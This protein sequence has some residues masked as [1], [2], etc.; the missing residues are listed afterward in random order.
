MPA[1]V[2]RLQAKWRQVSRVESVGWRGRSVLPW[3]GRRDSVGPCSSTPRA[4]LRWRASRET[5]RAVKRLDLSV[6][7]ALHQHVSCRRRLAPADKIG[8]YALRR[9]SARARLPRLRMCV[10][11][12][13]GSLPTG[14]RGLVNAFVLFAVQQRTTLH[15]LP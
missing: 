3:A 9:H 12:D 4:Q 5:F 2:S 1:V 8:R 6:K 15:R 14:S 7:H 11:R 13:P 10:A